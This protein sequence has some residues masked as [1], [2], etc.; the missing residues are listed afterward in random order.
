MLPIYTYAYIIHMHVYIFGG[1]GLTLT[2]PQFM[3]CQPPCVIEAGLAPQGIDTQPER[4]APVEA[5]YSKQGPM[6]SPGFVYCFT[7]KNE[8]IMIRIDD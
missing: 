6:V 1:E 2:L 8:I 4:A 7:L 5:L 3:S